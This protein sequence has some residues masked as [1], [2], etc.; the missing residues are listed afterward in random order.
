MK[1]PISLFGQVLFLINRADFAR[2][3]HKH[4]ANRHSN[5]FRC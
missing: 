5:G 1:H 2:L 4:R 3:V